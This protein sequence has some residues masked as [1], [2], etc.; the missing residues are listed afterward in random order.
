MSKTLNA[1]CLTLLASMM[2]QVT[3]AEQEK[4]YLD[5]YSFDFSSGM[6]PL[7]WIAR[8]NAVELMS[9][10]KLNPSVED[11]WGGYVFDGVFDQDKFE[12]EVE[13]VV[14]SELKDSRGLVAILSQNA[15]S[16]EDFEGAPTGFRDDY[17]G[18]GIYVYRHPVRSE[19]W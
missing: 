14:N 12:I 13:F 9:K 11:K 6:R 10:V 17:E 7:S 4:Y 18:I 5:N 15:I 1:I 3:M 16:N 19:Q 2:A 8:G